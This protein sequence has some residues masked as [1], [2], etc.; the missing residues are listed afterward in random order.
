M[1]SLLHVSGVR[2]LTQAAARSVYAGLTRGPLREAVLLESFQGAGL[3]G[4]PAAIADYVLEHTELPVIWSVRMD[5][6]QTNSRVSSVRYRSIA[7]FRALAT[8][9]YL[10]N[11]VTFP[12]VFDKRDDQVYLN[13]WHGTPL[14]K[15]GRDVDAPAEQIANTVSNLSCAD[16]LLSSSPYMTDTMYEQAYGV[17][18]G[19]VVELGTPRI[20]VQF[21]GAQDK[22]V[23]LYAPTW[24][25]QSYTEALVDRD[26]LSACLQALDRA[27]PGKVLLRVH[28]KVAELVAE[29][30]RLTPFLA[31][32]DESTNALLGRTKLLVT[33]Y[34]SVAFDALATGSTVVFY[35][36]DPYPRG[37]YLSDDQLPGPR[38]SSLEAL[39]DWVAH[40]PPPPPVPAANARARFCPQ[41][42]GHATERVV[43]RLLGQ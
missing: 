29:D 1:G 12:A 43:E 33:D 11:N 28:N 39:Q 32:A 18:T 22:D 37:V 15:M 7:Y 17:G 4:D 30:S 40:G 27:A 14:K 3:T 16:I 19:H 6:P 41:E 24:Q 2:N 23:V 26:Q 34:S 36:P 8:T 10:V 20:D 13:T 35:T 5:F 25:E 31:P 9:K 42:D 21:T 38:T